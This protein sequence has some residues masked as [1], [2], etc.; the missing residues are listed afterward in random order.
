M[1]VLVV[2]AHQNISNRSHVA[3]A[4]G[5]SHKPAVAVLETAVAATMQSSN[6]LHE[7]QLER[8]SCSGRLRKRSAGFGS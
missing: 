4:D 7:E 5:V 3:K 1:G 8:V 2:Q 6:G